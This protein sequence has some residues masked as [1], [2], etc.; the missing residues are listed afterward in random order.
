M[1]VRKYRSV[2]DM[3]DA[4]FRT[5]LDPDNLRIACALSEM[6]RALHPRVLPAGV[7]K[8]RSVSEAQTYATSVRSTS[9]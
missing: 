9:L 2:E 8:F 4:P 7:K 6:A 3:P 5:P 1:P